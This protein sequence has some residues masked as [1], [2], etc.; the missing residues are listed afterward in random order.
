MVFQ[1]HLTVV[2]LFSF[3]VPGLIFLANA[4]FCQFHSN[5]NIYLVNCVLRSRSLCCQNIRHLFQLHLPDRMFK[6]SMASAGVSKRTSTKLFY[7]SKTLK[8][9]SVDD[10]DTKRMKFYRSLNWVIDN[11]LCTERMWCNM[12]GNK[13]QSF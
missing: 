1:V 2:Q 6:S 5:F 8:L 3:V 10:P 9:L 7:G 11:L 12:K 4:M 13:W